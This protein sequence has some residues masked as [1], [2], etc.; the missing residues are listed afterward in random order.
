ML[1]ISQPNVLVSGFRPLA[2][3]GPGKSTNTT[4][5]RLADGTSFRPLAGYGPGKLA[6]F[7]RSH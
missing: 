1:A 6:L 2:G 3:Y 5:F 7:L 4:F